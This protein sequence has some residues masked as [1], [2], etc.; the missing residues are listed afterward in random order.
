MAEVT[1]SANN[2]I[3]I[4]KEAR[5]ALGL[6]AGDKLLVQVQGRT[7]IMVRKP[8]D[9]LKALMGIVPPGTYGDDYVRKERES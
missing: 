4:P 6:K 3:V 8:K 7:V 9:H 1:I 5:V 2:R